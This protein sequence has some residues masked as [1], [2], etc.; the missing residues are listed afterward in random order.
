[1]SVDTPADL[2][3]LNAKMRGDNS[4]RH[5]A[6]WETVEKY[7]RDGI[8]LMRCKQPECAPE[9]ADIEAKCNLRY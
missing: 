5:C 6:E 7:V 9:R 1:M 2:H 3:Y 4:V 8:V